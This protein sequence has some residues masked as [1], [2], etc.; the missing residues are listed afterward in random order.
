M[1]VSYHQIE[2]DPPT[3]SLSL[4]VLNIVAR[5]A[6]TRV[7]APKMMGVEGIEAV[8]T[9]SNVVAASVTDF[10]GYLF[11][12]FGIIALAG[13]ILFLAPPLADE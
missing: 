6:F 11:P 7:E 2:H 8:A 9:S 3:W 10:G 1:L 4:T 5:P 13:V 12:V